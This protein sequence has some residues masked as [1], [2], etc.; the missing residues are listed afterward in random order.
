M[1]IDSMVIVSSYQDGYQIK[2]FL[3]ISKTHQSFWVVQSRKTDELLFLGSFSGC[4]VVYI[5]FHEKIK[6]FS[7]TD[8]RRYVYDDIGFEF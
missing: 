6:T 2:T 8:E 4:P 3:Y 1:N 5:E 7:W